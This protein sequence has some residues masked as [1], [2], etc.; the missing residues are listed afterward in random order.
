MK[1]TSLN[2]STS[3]DTI[4]LLMLPLF[5]FTLLIPIGLFENEYYLVTEVG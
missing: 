2:I 3:F 4:V 1:Y 5:Y